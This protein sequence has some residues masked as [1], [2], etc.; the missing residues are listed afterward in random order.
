MMKEGGLEAVAQAHVK[1]NIS[2]VISKPEL[3]MPAK[4]GQPRAAAD[5]RT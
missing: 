2:S 3:G 5:A 4:I 1:F